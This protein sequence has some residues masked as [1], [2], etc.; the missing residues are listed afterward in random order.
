MLSRYLRC[1]PSISYPRSIY[2]ATPVL[3]FAFG[4]QYCAKMLTFTIEHSAWHHEDSLVS[5]YSLPRR[6][7][8][9]AKPPAY[10]IQQQSENAEVSTLVLVND[11]HS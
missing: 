1:D 10:I 7:G 3:S 9:R 5:K 6:H 4:L 2:R 11:V 8:F